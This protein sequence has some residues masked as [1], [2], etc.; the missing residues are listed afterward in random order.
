[1]LT[2]QI[3]DTI[4]P[5][6][7]KIKKFQNFIFPQRQNENIL[8][9]FHILVGYKNAYTKYNGMCIKIWWKH[10]LFIRVIAKL[11]FSSCC[12]LPLMK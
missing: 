8:L 12:K 2:I 6:S 10:I 4:V 1:M 7:E 11:A 5:I 3:Y 9:K